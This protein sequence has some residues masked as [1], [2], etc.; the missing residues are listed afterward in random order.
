M[1]VTDS[2]IVKMQ[3]LYE[4]RIIFWVALAESEHGYMC[5]GGGDG[6]EAGG[7]SARRGGGSESFIFW[8]LLISCSHV[9]AW[10]AVFSPQ[11]CFDLE[12][13]EM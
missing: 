12:G 10:T 13:S 1:I 2:I 4:Y 9:C 7:G 3:Y 5:V 11:T 8:E 6:R